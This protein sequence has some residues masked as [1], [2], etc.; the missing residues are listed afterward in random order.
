MIPF[1]Y[2]HILISP[3]A[4]LSAPI[5]NDFGNVELPRNNRGIFKRQPAPQMRPP[6]GRQGGYPTGI[7][8]G[9]PGPGIAVPPPINYPPSNPMPMNP[10]YNP[11]PMNPMYNPI[12]MNP[13]TNPM[14]MNPMPNQMSMNPMAMNPMIAMAAASIP[15]I[16][17][18]LFFDEK[19]DNTTSDVPELRES[20]SGQQQFVSVEYKEHN[21]ES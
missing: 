19:G 8:G 18:P 11:M 7:A 9:P 2:L 5:I 12:P 17:W 13:M 21:P 10:M 3:L 14:P 4:I 6:P 15:P 1:N 20:S 16:L